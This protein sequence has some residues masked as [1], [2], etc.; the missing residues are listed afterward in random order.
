MASDSD[1]DAAMKQIKDLQAR[2]TTPE[3]RSR[4]YQAM[5]AKINASSDDI[6]AQVKKLAEQTIT[7]DKT[8][9]SI[10]QQLIIVDNNDYKDKNGLPIAKLAP[11]WKKYQ[12]RYTDLLWGARDAAI[13]TE[14]YLRDLVDVIFP[15]ILE[16]DS[17]YQDN[18]KDLTSFA[19]RRNPLTSTEADDDFNKLKA[20]V[21]AF[22]ENFSHFAEDE[23]AKLSAEIIALQNDIKT[24]QKELT[25]LNNLVEQMG[26]A[27]GITVGA[28]TGGIIAAVL[29]LG[30]A[31]G[32]AIIP[33]LVTGIAAIIGETAQL[34]KALTRKA[35]VES[36][37]SHKQQEID[38]LS[39]QQ[40][41]L[42]ELKAKLEL[43]ADQGGDMFGRLANF[44]D[45]WANC[46]QDAKS[47]LDVIADVHTD[48]SVETRIMLLSDTYKTVADA[49]AF[50]A[51]YLGN[52]EPSS[53]K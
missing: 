18:V 10:R 40:K 8:F 36:D 19:E 31:A 28:G 12:D 13:K 24:L 42:Q 51:T 6:M 47:L 50:Y 27:I 11:T 37:I 29:V 32:T 26:I 30:P 34:I 22:V 53:D 43:C 48:R 17:T 33:I 7:T 41:V 4:A 35:T 14:A 23:G 9:Q 46:A 5:S 25:D 49:L 20:D 1:Y 3:E 44:S 38:H 2:G 52:Y 45:M 15:V 39:A 16:N 21:T